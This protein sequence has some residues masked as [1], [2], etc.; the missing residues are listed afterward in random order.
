MGNIFKRTVAMIC[1]VCLVISGEGSQCF[2]AVADWINE[3]RIT[4]AEEAL[5][6]DTPVVTSEAV[7]DDTVDDTVTVKENAVSEGLTIAAAD[8]TVLPIAAEAL[9]FMVEGDEG[10]AA[11][12]LVQEYMIATE[13]AEALAAETSEGAADNMGE[14][15]EIIADEMAISDE[16]AA[17]VLDSENPVINDSQAE[18]MDEAQPTVLDTAA[19][20]D[21]TAAAVS[22]EKYEAAVFDIS[23]SNVDYSE[24]TQGFKVNYTLP[25][26]ILSQEP[27]LS[28]ASALS[29]AEA[30][31]MPS[32]ENASAARIGRYRLFHIHDG[33]VTEIED[34]T[35]SDGILSFVTPDFSRFVLVYTV[36]F[37][38]GEYTYNLVGGGEIF[39]SELL[40]ILQNG[41]RNSEV[42][43]ENGGV[44]VSPTT[45]ERERLGEIIADMSQIESVA[46][47][48]SEL[49]KVEKKSSGQK[50]DDWLLTSFAA[51]DSEEA[52]TITFKDGSEL[53]ISVTDEQV[54]ETSE[55]AIARVSD[56]G[57]N[58]WTYFDS[59]ITGDTNT[60][61]FDHVKTLSGN[62]IVELLK[63]TDGRYTLTSGVTYGDG[64]NTFN[65]GTGNP[66]IKNLT[67]R[68]S[69]ADSPAKLVKTNTAPLLII[70]IK[71]CNTTIEN[72]IIDGGGVASTAN[73]GVF[74]F[75]TKDRGSNNGNA[76]PTATVRN[77][78][79]KN[80]QSKGSGGA[81]YSV[82]QLTLENC[83]FDSCRASSH[84][85]AVYS[86]TSVYV[87][88]AVGEAASF[89][90]CHAGG[91]GGA[92]YA[93][94]SIELNDNVGT[95]LFD[96]CFAVG[97]GGALRSPT[98]T[99]DNN[100]GDIT[101]TGCYTTAGNAEGGVAQTS[102][103]FSAV[104]NQGSILFTGCHTQGSSAEGG[105]LFG[106][107]G[108]ITIKCAEDGTL[109]FENVTANASDGG[110]AICGWSNC[111]VTVEGTP[112]HPVEFEN[113]V[114]KNTGESRGGGAVYIN[115]G[116]GTL[117]H[118]RANDCKSKYGGAF[119]ANSSLTMTDCV[120]TNCTK[121]E[122]GGIISGG[123]AIRA[124]I[125]RPA[126][127]TDH[128]L[129]RRDE[130]WRGV[131]YRRQ[132]HNRWQYHGLFRQERLGGVR[133]WRHLHARWGRGQW[134][135]RVFRRLD[136]DRQR[137][138]HFQGRCKG[139]LR[140]V[141]QERVSG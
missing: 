4:T 100:T 127:C 61:A 57:G 80:C 27:A 88:N 136:T 122:T 55:D 93:A 25:Q 129:L 3:R 13:T 35:I 11:L 81:V 64:S 65:G 46:F 50:E 95:L 5:N 86:G 116:S 7:G 91:E 112:E 62:V 20:L 111:V 107:G 103:L 78:E 99:M 97:D 47:S 52:L 96:S 83:S 53:K 108:I 15:S 37:H 126:C 75:T 43:P 102:S 137:K 10:K 28:S 73:G 72:L 74:Q 71:S 98:I 17:A 101:F 51:F 140:R 44:D 42:D 92:I 26:T 56:D 54:D 94:T 18:A 36:D 131:R 123:G 109:R 69:N 2:A 114:A 76:V 125:R 130:R 6:D 70:N 30:A 132:L 119:A 32:D 141:R 45:A 77:V 31:D 128:G 87:R 33:I 24:Y 1:A 22:S 63:E 21:S 120:I 66:S 118:V 82:C 60:G 12:K 79:F 9:S 84:G 134:K 23:L 58:T 59:L 133:V 29:S 121:N 104:N 110:G 85:G 39:L 115:A 14:D 138:T 124:D 106:Y 34:F 16:A 38:W 67:I 40:G 49:M 139:P 90:G 48:N 89:I 19:M 8:G 105:A 41:Y 135:Q 68:S 113:C 117:K